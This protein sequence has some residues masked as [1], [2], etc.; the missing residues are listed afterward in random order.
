MRMAQPAGRQ[1]PTCSNASGWLSL[2]ADGGHPVATDPDGSSLPAGGGHPVATDAAAADPDGSACGQP[3]VTLQQRIRMAQPAG[4]RRPPCSNRSG[5]LKPAGSRRPPCSNGC[6]AADPDGSACG[7]PEVTLQQR[8]RMAQPA[9]SRRSWMA[10]P[11]GSRRSPR[12]SG[13]GCR[14]AGGHPDPDGSALTKAQAYRD[15][16][17]SPQAC[18]GQSPCSKVPHT[19]GEAESCLLK[20]PINGQI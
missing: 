17:T 16:Y 1:R 11:A 7:Q 18:C 12:S 3:E 8:I 14:L 6:A 5:W 2:P 4:R 19:R 9:G 13:S 15:L 10:Q 20:T